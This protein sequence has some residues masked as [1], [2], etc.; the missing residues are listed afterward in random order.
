MYSNCKVR[1]NIKGKLYAMTYGKAVSRAI[2]PIE[3]KPL[4]HFLP[5]S[6]AYSIATVG[7]N[8]HCK[9]CQNFVIS[10]A[11]IEKFPEHLDLPPEKVVEEAIENNCEV[12]A[13]TYT[14]PTIFYEYVL[15]TARIAKKKGLKN[16]IV[17]NGYINEEPLKELYKYIDAVNVDLKGF[18]EEFY[19]DI[20]GAKLEPVLDTLQRLQ[21]IKISLEIT[22][23]IIPTKN[24]SI[25]QIREMC[26]WI[27]KNLGCDHPLHFSRFFPMYKLKNLE[28]T[29]KRILVEAKKTAEEE[30]IKYVY[31]GNMRE[32]GEENT[33]CPKCKTLLVK[34]YG[35]SISEMNI[36]S[37]KCACKAKIKGVWKINGS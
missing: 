5:G 7:C 15:D 17:T 18:T 10:Q 37:D 21:N 29:P 35:F 32:E 11:S 28:P 34:R 19:Q 20:C 16:I 36:K 24:D 1:K 31:I 30:G 25:K 12:I 4:F 14:E 33:Y 26:K 8:L 13:Y 9:H 3:K 22:N 23:L 2:D 27:V 6:R